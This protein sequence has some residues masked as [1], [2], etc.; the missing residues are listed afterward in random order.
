MVRLLRTN[1]FRLAVLY[2]GLFATSVLALLAFIYW[3]TAD[4]IEKQ[5]EAT[6]DAEIAGLAEQYDQ[7]GLSGLVQV[8]AERSAGERGDAMLYLITDPLSHPLAGNLSAWP[9]GDVIRPGWIAFPVEVGRGANRA[10][11][12]ARATTFTI[13]GGYRLLVGRDLRDATAFRKRVTDT[14]AWAG[15]LTLGLG[16]AGGAFMSRNMLRRVEAVSNTT[17]EIIHGDLGKRVPLSGSGDEFDQLAANLNAMLDQ[18]ERLMEGMRQVT[19]NIAH[20]LRTPL[21]R[22]RARLEVALIEKPDAARAAEVMRETIAEADR[23]LGTFNALLSIAEAESGSRRAA[24]E[25][26]DLAEIVGSVAEL[27]EPLAEEK[28]LTLTVTASAGV[29]VRGDPHLLAQAAANL[30]D[31]AI[32]YT[33]SGGVRLTVA[34]DEGGGRIEVADSGPGIPEDRREA[35]FD[36]FV[37]L[38][39]SRSTPGNGLGLSLV[40][41]VGLLHGGTITLADN[42][43]GL[44]AILRLPAATGLPAVA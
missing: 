37:R 30:L 16:L 23:L 28:G 5:T 38:E 14:L 36:R 39:G 31:N 42:G 32:K 11:H 10:T 9:D 13:P 22:L 17:A 34:A 6:L 25:E 40:R 1:A 44:R 12:M 33:E 21:S 35:V 20:D 8:I 41:A 7:R 43:P 24:M 27:Y 2:L 26:V 29:R 19:D 15:V 18:I 3:S 4:F